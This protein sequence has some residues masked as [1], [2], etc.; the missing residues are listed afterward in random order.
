MGCVCEEMAGDVLD[1]SHTCIGHLWIFQEL[2]AEELHTL[3]QEAFRKKLSRSQINFY[4][5]DPAD[6]IILIKAGRVKLTK[7]LESGTEITLDIRKAGDFIG[8]NMLS[9]EAVYPMTVTC[10]EDVLVCGF[11][12]NQFEKL[13]LS[14]P[15]IGLQVI[16]NLSKRISLLTDRVEGLS[17]SKLED[18][19]YRVLSTMA[20]EHGIEN[21]NG[22]MI[23]FP[24]THEDLSF[25]VGA[26]RVSVTRTLKELKRSG[27]IID[28][29][30]KI[31]LPNIIA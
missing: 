14:H 18:R 9:E 16:K 15:K 13:I 4:Q 7:V 26:H 28:Q 30:K 5:G 1:V 21:P 23:E 11:V 2:E 24:L 6:E 8:E 22:Y 25:L 17:V 31:F 10:M 29:G 19:P 20:Q 27:K 3:V 12:R